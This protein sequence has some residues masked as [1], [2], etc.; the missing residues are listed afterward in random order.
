MP[1]LTHILTE[2]YFFTLKQAKSAI[3]AGSFLFLIFAS[4]YIT[5]PGLY[6]YDFLFLS[7]ILI[8]I[9]LLLTKLETKDEAK[10]IFLFHIIGMILEIY[11]TNPAI[12]SWT[13]PEAG[14]FKIFDVPLYG[15]F[16]YASIGSYIASAYKNL[17]LKLTNNPRWQYAVFLATV[18][19]I[20]FFTNHF[21]YDIRYFLI[22][23]I[24]LFYIKTTVYFTPNKKEY[25][26]P[27]FIGF[28]LIAFFIWIAEN[29]GTFYGAWL[30]PN[31][32]HAWNVVSLH[33]ITSWFLMLIIS[34]IIVTYLKIYKENRGVKKL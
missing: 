8:Q 20:N 27:I 33:K 18:I 9:I 16:M 1:T 11:K 7:A 12:G 31:Q 13:Y 25:K 30:Y 3:F 5:I 14:F 19:Y 28:I 23:A 26:M 29:I 24:F 15:G 10:T 2:L 22:T 4:K 21:V 6:R 17:K 32:I 34:F